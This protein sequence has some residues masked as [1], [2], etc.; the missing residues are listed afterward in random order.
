MLVTEDGIVTDAMAAQSE[1]ALAPMLVTEE[2]M[3]TD[4]NPPGASISTVPSLLRSKP[5]TDE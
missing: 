3:E 5:S 1:N 2:G 4:V